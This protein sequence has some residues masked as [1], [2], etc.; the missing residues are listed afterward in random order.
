MFLFGQAAGRMIEELTGTCEIRKVGDLDEAVRSAWQCARPGE[1]VLLS[2][3][4][5]SYDMFRDYEDRGEQYKHRVRR[6]L[7]GD[8]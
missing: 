7:R 4:C 3:A 5:S 8:G 2:P 1:T 6:I